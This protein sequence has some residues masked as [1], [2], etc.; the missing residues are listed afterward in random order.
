[1]GTLPTT[2]QLSGNFAGQAA[3][4][5]P[6]TGQPFPGNII[7]SARLSPLTQRIIGFLPPLNRGGA[8]NYQAA[9]SSRNDFDQ[10]TARLDH[11]FSNADLFYGRF[12]YSDTTLFAPGLI[13]QSGSNVTD[14][15]QNGVLDWIHNFKPNLLNELRFGVN[16]NLQDRLQEGAN[17]PD[18]L[19]FQNIFADPVNHGLPLVAM[20][21]YSSFG[22]A[23]T[24][25]EIV[26]GTTYQY[27]DNVTWIH[28]NH[29]LKFGVDVRFMQFPHLPVLF[30]RGQYVFS[31]GITG[32][33]VADFLVGYPLVSIGAGLG[34][35]A[36]MSLHQ[37]NAFVQDDWKLAHGF[38]L[39]LG[40]RYERTG[41][42]TDRFRGRLGIFDERTGQVVKGAAVDKTG[43]V[44]PDN[45]NFGPRVGFAW[46]PFRSGRT[47]IRG[48]Y[49]LYYDVKPVNELNFSLGTE[50]GFRQIVSTTTQWDTLFPPVGA[51]SGVG[52]LT[53]DPFARTP[54][55][56]QYS[57]GIQRELMPNL[58]L[59]ATYT[60]SEGRKLNRRIDLNQGTLPAFAGQPLTARQPYPTLGSIVMAK[61]IA[62]SN[63]NAFEL[64]AEQRFSHNLTFIA[65]YTWAK[66]LDTSSIAGDSTSGQRGHSSKPPQRESRVWPFRV[67]S[68]SSFRAELCVHAPVRLGTEVSRV[69]DR[70][71]EPGYQWMAG[72]RYYDDGDR[73]SVYSPSLR[74]RSHSDRSVRRR[75]SAR[76]CRCRAAD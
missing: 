53:D 17:G 34:P 60:G 10:F 2:Q 3:I 74:S 50:L 4:K 8:N 65:A 72:Q 13:R 66:S 49:G 70:P 45:N 71:R 12:T 73:Q 9:P 55:V 68:T 38:T 57:F 64:R 19:Q 30:G 56:Q 37:V 41:V 42:I 6:A 7:P 40:L 47:V 23:P 36:F 63:Y 31:G 69:G 15:P 28:N 24:N 33:P 54:Y 27:D 62:N 58:L 22:T 29:S 67:R 11:R 18:I 39:N 32:N 16:R 43:L 59:E 44:N 5:D 20:T 25:P 48:G 46:Q 21:G 1:M 75:Q 52:I 61:D 35:S 76:Q 51:T 14:T 26:G